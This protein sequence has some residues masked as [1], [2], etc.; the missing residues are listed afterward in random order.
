MNEHY[1]PMPPFGPPLKYTGEVYNRH[2]RYGVLCTVG[3][4]ND[5]HFDARIVCI[6]LPEMSDE[7][8]RREMYDKSCTAYVELLLATRY[9]VCGEDGSG[10][11]LVLSE[12]IAPVPIELRLTKNEHLIN[13]PKELSQTLTPKLALAYAWTIYQHEP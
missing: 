7:S 2:I 6:D 10:G 11:K 13:L 1:Q 12:S 4:T 3:I 9:E 8:I 5:L